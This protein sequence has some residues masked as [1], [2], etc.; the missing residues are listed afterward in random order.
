[1]NKLCLVILYSTSRLLSLVGD[2][3]LANFHKSMYAMFSFLFYQVLTS[4]FVRS[5]L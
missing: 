3:P 5:W 1:M 2:E 4:P